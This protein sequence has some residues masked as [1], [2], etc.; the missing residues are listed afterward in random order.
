MG[1]DTHLI[2]NDSSLLRSNFVLQHR[3]VSVFEPSQIQNTLQETAG[4]YRLKAKQYRD[5]AQL[6]SDH[7][8]REAFELLADT[9]DRLA[10]D[11]ERI[12]SS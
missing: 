5:A 3:V 10:A 8:R 4:Q 7:T 6:E 1:C 12:E 9:F 2:R 11:Y